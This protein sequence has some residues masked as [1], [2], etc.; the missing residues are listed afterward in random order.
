MHATANK[1]FRNLGYL[2]LYKDTKNEEFVPYFLCAYLATSSICR[3]KITNAIIK[4]LSGV[5][6]KRNAI[7]SPMLFN[8]RN[9]TIKHPT[10]RKRSIKIVM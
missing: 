6:S 9:T 5:L 7:I 2:L 8:L 4:R 1:H 10:R 3:N